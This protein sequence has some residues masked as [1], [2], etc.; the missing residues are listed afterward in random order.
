MKLLI[1]QRRAPRTPCIPIWNDL[2]RGRVLLEKT[3]CVIYPGMHLEEGSH[4]G[5]E[6]F[7][8]KQWVYSSQFL[9]QQTVFNKDE[10]KM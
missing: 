3:L 2:E 7:I 1:T 10:Q 8:L 4:S 9:L 6:R 5:V